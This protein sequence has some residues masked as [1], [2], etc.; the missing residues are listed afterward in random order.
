[1]MKDFTLGVCDIQEVL[2]ALNAFW[3]TLKPVTLTLLLSSL[4][5]VYLSMPSSSD[6]SMV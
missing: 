1:M 3:A 5:V 6:D 4:A 2:Y